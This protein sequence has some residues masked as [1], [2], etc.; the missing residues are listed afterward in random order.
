MS[1]QKRF[2]KVAVLLG[3]PSSERA[4][5]LRSGAAV[6]KALRE[7]GYEVAEVLV[8]EDRS[9]AVPPGTEVAFVAMHG[10]FGE[11]GT[12]QA[13][14]RK[15]GIPHTGSSPE[16]SARAFDKSQSKPV[17]VAAGIPTPP[18]EFLRK[19]QKRTLPLPVVVKPV[20][21]GSSVG[22]SRVFHEAEWPAALAAALG[23]DEIALVE[24]FI[25][26]RELTVGVV[27]DV[28]LPVME[29]VA[30]DGFFDYRAKYTA[31]VSQHVFPR[32]LPEATA[33]ACQAAARATFQALGCSGMG[34]VDIRLRPDGK[35]FVLE[36]NNIPGM[37]E[38]SLLPDAARAHGWSFPELCEI[39]LNMV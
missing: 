3:G 10:H 25:P 35:F 21:Q 23:Y 12:I 4:V 38:I 26:G 39:I 37:T 6:A 20:R 17:I 29:I 33:R 22:V 36:L 9:F 27:G 7:R 30:P 13:L 14:L 28:V 31:G 34:R 8:G 24:E 16:A 5:S 2:R 18:F 32:D 11:D 19:G 1:G 15:Q